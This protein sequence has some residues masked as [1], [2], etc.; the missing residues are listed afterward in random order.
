[1]DSKLVPVYAG[2]SGS[3]QQE[4]QDRLSGSRRRGQD[5][6]AVT[7]EGGRDKADEPDPAALLVGADDG[8]AHLQGVGPGRVRGGEEDVAQIC[9]R[10]RWHH[11]S[12]RL[13]GRE[14]LRG[15]QDLAAGDTRDAGAG[16]GAHRHPRQ[17]D[18]Q[19]GGSF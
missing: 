15:E 11:L 13:L 6:A 1:V 7:F 10:R 9:V 5:D 2:E 17:Q 18:R 3:R 4:D 16:E 14:A 8:G 12:G 19:G